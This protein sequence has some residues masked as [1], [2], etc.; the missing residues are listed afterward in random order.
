MVNKR[1][2]LVEDFMKFK[3]VYDPQLSPDGSKILYVLSKMEDEKYL[4]NIWIYDVATMVNRQFTYSDGD[5]RP[6][7]SPDGQQIA[8]ISKRNGKKQL[9]VMPINGGEA[10]PLVE[11]VYGVGD[12]VWSPC[13]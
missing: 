10:R 6:R 2:F 9:F 12:P 8:F 4:P 7:W 5:E 13:G 1:Q 11:F 3:F